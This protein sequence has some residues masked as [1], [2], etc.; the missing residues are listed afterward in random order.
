MDLLRGLLSYL[1]N[2][3]DNGQRLAYEYAKRDAQRLVE[4]EKK[5]FAELAKQQVAEKEAELKAELQV[6]RGGV[7]K[8]GEKVDVGDV[9]CSCEAAD[10]TEGSKHWLWVPE[11][12]MGI[13]C[14]RNSCGKN[15]LRCSQA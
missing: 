15:V 12:R 10:C 2:Q 3:M 1:L 14:G 13:Y 6:G 9:G 5:R 4:E 8:A 7:G 11:E